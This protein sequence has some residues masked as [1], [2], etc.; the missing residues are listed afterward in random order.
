ML[1]GFGIYLLVKAVEVMN[2]TAAA[3]A[4]PA[5]IT[6]VGLLCFFLGFLG[7]FGAL[8]ESVCMLNT[9]S[10]VPFNY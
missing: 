4:L 7:C 6:A 1:S 5:F 10:I 2:G 8:N 9:A 3:I